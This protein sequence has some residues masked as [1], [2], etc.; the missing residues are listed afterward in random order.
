[1]NFVAR[2]CTCSIVVGC[3]AVGV[4]F[5]YG[6]SKVAGIT[7]IAIQS[8]HASC[9]GYIVWLLRFLFRVDLQ[10]LLSNLTNLSGNI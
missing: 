10:A 9:L 4:V 5:K 8:L 3:L 1:M 2:F 6:N 7:L